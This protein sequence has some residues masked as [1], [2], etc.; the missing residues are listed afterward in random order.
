MCR[1]PREHESTTEDGLIE[2]SEKLG[3]I[4]HDKLDDLK[5]KYSNHL[6]YVF[7]KGFVAALVFMD[8]DGNPLSKTC[9]KISE[10]A[11]KEVCLLYILEENLLN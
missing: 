7:G 2:K 10:L 4:F 5:N 1:W 8:S 9:D 11:S 3:K 6:A